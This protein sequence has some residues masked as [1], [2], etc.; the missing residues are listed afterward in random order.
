[1]ELR[2]IAMALA[3]TACGGPETAR[4]ADAGSA[5]MPFTATADD[6][7]GFTGWPALV[8]DGP[9]MVDAAM[10]T[11]GVR[12]VYLNQAPPAGALAFP[13]GT[14]IVKTIVA[15]PAFPSA[16]RTFAMAKRGRGYNSS[17]A[18]GWEWFEL[19]PTQSPPAILWRGL[20]PP[21][22]DTY[23][24]ESSCNGCHILAVGNDFVHSL[25]LAK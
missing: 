16:V 2:R 13:I 15:N 17:G 24:G 4:Q 19:D 7:A 21:V 10:H 5:P 22:G 14:V 18:V 23:N 11:T 25:P 6:F 1:V 8:L 3:L 9:A 12:T 20:G